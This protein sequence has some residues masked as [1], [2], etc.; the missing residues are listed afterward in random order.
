M[1]NLVIAAIVLATLLLVIFADRSEQTPDVTQ[2]FPVEAPSVIRIVVESDR[3]RFELERGDDEWQIVQPRVLPADNDVVSALLG[4]LV[5]LQVSEPVVATGSG[6]ESPQASVELS[7][8][9]QTFSLRLGAQSEFD[10]RVYV[11]QPGGAVF[12]APG[13]LLFQ[14]RKSELDL[15]DA[16]VVPI[17][18]E[19]IERFSV[20]GSAGALAAVRRDDRYRVEGTGERLDR[21]A[22]VALLKVAA[23]T[24]ATRLVPEG[25]PVPEDAI[26]WTFSSADETVTVE[27]WQT[28]EPLRHWVASSRLGLVELSSPA[29]HRRLSANPE[30]LLDNRVFELEPRDV[31]GLQID[32]LT[33]KRDETGWRLP[34]GAR[35]DPQKVA[36][37]LYNLT[38]LERGEPSRRADW[39]SSQTLRLVR[40]DEKTEWFQMV[41]DSGGTGYG[42]LSPD[43]MAFRFDATQLG[44]LSAE[45][46]AY[47]QR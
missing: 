11:A 2:L 43:G 4:Y 30:V 41:R 18:P 46:S 32:G 36:A 33:L 27:L 28:Y 9:K 42:R 44:T 39:S 38:K 45:P 7:T 6:V 21:A 16:R 17:A 35:A 15:R 23:A 37:L 10:G 12:L 5:Q 13:E 24:R 31:T 14:L 19:A 29:F 3:G 20:R 34:S 22:V 26:R 1:R 25:K 8:L 47:L 40:S